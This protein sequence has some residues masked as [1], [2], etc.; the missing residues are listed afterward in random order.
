M[1]MEDMGVMMITMAI[2][3]MSIMSMMSI[4][5]KEESMKVVIMMK[6]VMLVLQ[7]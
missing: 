6:M 3:M 7:S 2:M 5:T 1:A 4:I